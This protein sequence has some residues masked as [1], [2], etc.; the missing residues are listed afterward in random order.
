MT[1]EVINIILQLLQ[2]AQLSGQEVPAYNLAVAVLNDLLKD[3][4]PKLEES[5]VNE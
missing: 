4:E 3:T 2:R 5:A 1:K